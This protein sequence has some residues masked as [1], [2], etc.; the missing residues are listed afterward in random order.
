MNGFSEGYIDELRRTFNEKAEKAEQDKQDWWASLSHV[1]KAEWL[2]E[3]V[4]PTMVFERDMPRLALAQVHATL[5]LSEQP[6][7]LKE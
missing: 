1:E 2:L 5:A 4:D 6:K 3:K 7:T